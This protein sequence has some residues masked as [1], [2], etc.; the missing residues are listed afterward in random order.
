[1]RGFK[2][3]GPRKKEAYMAL[4]N[5]LL[6]EDDLARLSR[7]NVEFLVDRIDTILNESPEVQKLIASKLESA[8]GLV[9]PDARLHPAG[10]RKAS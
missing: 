2:T 8:V 7:D 5:Q 3:G 6:S 4:L 10:E 1:M 9:A